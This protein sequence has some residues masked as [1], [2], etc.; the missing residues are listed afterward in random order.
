MNGGI[1]T[2]TESELIVTSSEIKEK[3]SNYASFYLDKTNI[4]D[5]FIKSID[6]DAASVSAQFS[7]KSFFPS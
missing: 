7:A 2:D 1:L 3:A 4:I 5:L 6:K